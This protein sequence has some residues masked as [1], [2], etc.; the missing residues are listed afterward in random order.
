MTNQNQQQP[1]KDQQKQAKP[2]HE[3]TV[4]SGKYV[5]LPARS[6]NASSASACKVTMR[7]NESKDS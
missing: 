7:A 1:Q 2:G 5:K 6:N 3:I 4:L